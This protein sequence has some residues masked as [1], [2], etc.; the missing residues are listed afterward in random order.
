MLEADLPI[1]GKNFTNHFHC[2]KQRISGIKIFLICAKFLLTK[3]CRV[4]Y[5]G[6]SG[7][8]AVDSP[9]KL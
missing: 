6:I 4:W 8:F 2:A 5:N 7:C 9:P 3:W 1:L